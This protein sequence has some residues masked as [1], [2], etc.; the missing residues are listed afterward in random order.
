MPR[1]LEEI[2]FRHPVRARAQME[3]VS[4]GL[5]EAIA[6]RIQ[7]LLASV[8]DPDQS[9]H[10]LERFRVENPAGFDRITKSPV[11]LGHL[12]TIFSYSTFLSEA[13][14]RHPEWLLQL[15][16]SGDLDRVLPADDYAQRLGT[17]VPP[18]AVPAAVD[19]ARFRRQ[20]LL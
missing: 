10:Y 8:P 4:N 19:L 6:A 14:L 2:D 18:A 11:A 7:V 20:Q 16:A 13:V 17:L 3:E 9:L 15:T 5:P 1:L 12:I